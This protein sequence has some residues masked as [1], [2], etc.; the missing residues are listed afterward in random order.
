[1]IRKGWNQS[2]LARQAALHT[3]GGKFG[4]DVVSGYLRGRN[5]PG[6][7]HLQALAMALSVAREDLLPHGRLPTAAS[8]SAPPV[9]VKEAEEGMAYV[10]INKKV[11]W[12]TA[13][14]IQQ[15]LLE[16]R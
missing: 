2:E 8:F 10:K 16:D 6:P 13:L 3:E 7:S 14:K 4:R 12:E 1:M 9:E 5:L 11:R 15:V